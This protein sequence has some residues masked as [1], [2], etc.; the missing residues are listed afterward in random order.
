MRGHLYIAATARLAGR[1]HPLLPNP[2]STSSRRAI[3]G[4]GSDDGAANN[5]FGRRSLHQW[6]GLLLYAAGYPA[7][8]AGWR[9]SAGGVPIP[10]SP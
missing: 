2:L 4:Y 3:A 1:I 9:L 10:S 5:G 7:P 6:E 8:P